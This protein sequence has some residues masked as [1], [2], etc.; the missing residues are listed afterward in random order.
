MF[1]RI[2]GSALVLS[3]LSISMGA[4]AASSW[5]YKDPVTWKKTYP[6]CDKGFQ[7]P[8]DF[9]QRRKGMVSGKR[10]HIKF[11]AGSYKAQVV[12]NGHA[13]Q[14]NFPGERPE[15][16]IGKDYY[17]VLQF[18]FHSLSEHTVNGKHAPGELHI[19][20][21]LNG[22]RVDR[23]LGVLLTRGRSNQVIGKILLMAPHRAGMKSKEFMF[24][25]SDF[26]KMLPTQRSYYAYD[27]SLTT[28]P[29]TDG[30]RWIVFK[31][32]ETISANQVRMLQGFYSHNYRPTQD[33][34][35]RKIEMAR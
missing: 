5:N 20:L 33:L 16:A 13:V 6:Q 18:H 21:S 10:L 34:R 11:I 25:G 2:L 8:V 29:C 22:S 28:P 17:H 7:S 19:V 12:N 4:L 9:N 3:A 35:G 15:V 23:V 31:N 26:D 30:V 32:P 14:V 27:G 1:K 24:R